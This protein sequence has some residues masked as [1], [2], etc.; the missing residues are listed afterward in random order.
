[1]LLRQLLKAAD[2]Y[3]TQPAVSQ[4]IK[5]LEEYYGCKLSI[6]PT[7]NLRIKENS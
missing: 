1:M 2:L 7:E 5:Y 6:Q 3:I 4:H